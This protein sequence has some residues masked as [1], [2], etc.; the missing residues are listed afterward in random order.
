AALMSVE[1]AVIGPVL[2]WLIDRLGEHRLI[3]VGIVIF[4]LGLIAMGTVDSL[5]AFYAAVL[6]IALGTSL[7]GYFPINVAII[8]WF[9]R[10]RARALSTVGL[11]MAL[12]GIF[13]PVVAASMAA[14]G[15]R[16]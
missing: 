8:H 10:R 11:G 3:R 15:W 12:G 7:A 6:M 5:A 4:G 2:G 13:V 16:A 1:T 14:F 9:E